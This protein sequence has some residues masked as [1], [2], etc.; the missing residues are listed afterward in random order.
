MK[1]GWLAW[2][3]MA[4]GL[5]LAASAWADPAPFDLA[6]PELRITITRHGATLP[7][8]AVP[9]LSAGD[10]LHIEALMPA[11]ETAHYVLV[12]ASL[13]DPTNPPPD[14]WFARSET[15]KRPGHGGGAIDITV[16]ADARHLVVY[17]APATI[18]DFS[19]LRDAVKGR[20]GAF[21]R[22]AQDLEQASLDR[23]RYD[24][25]LAA[26][27]KLAAQ[28]PGTL[29]KVAPVLAESLRI[30]INEE[31]L[32][33]QKELQAACLLDAKQ[34]VVLGNDDTSNINALVGV[35]TD[36][37]L[38]LSATPAG[39]MGYYSPYIS[40]IHELFGI[41]SA[42]HTAKYQYIP[43]LGVMEGER[44]RLVLNTP[45]SF[46]NP[47][48]VLMAALP[49]VKAPSPPVPQRP[50]EAAPLCYGAQAPVLSLTANPLFYATGY[51]RDLALR[52][53][54]PGAAQVDVPLSA[55]AGKGGFVAGTMAA[56]KDLTG[57][58]T[59]T[60]HGQWG[61]DSFVGP[62]VAMVV[63]GAWHWQADPAHDKS[64]LVFAGAPSACVAGVRVRA[65]HGM[66]QAEAW[67]ADGA[68]KIIVT[69]P[70]AD[71]H[72]E[73]IEVEIAGPQGVAP[74]KVAVAAPVK[75]PPP[76][77]SVVAH[78]SAPTSDEGG[79][80]IVLDSADE[81][82]ANARL[83]LTLKAA[84]DQPFADH[85]MLEITATNAS[86]SAHLSL[87]GGL[88][89]VD[90]HVLV[91]TLIPAQAL[92][93]SAY[94]SLRAR[95]VRG[96][97]PGEWMSVGKLVRLP[98]LRSLECPVDAGASCVLTGDTLYLLASVSAERSFEA[99]TSIAE[100]YPGF[101]LKIPHPGAGG[102]LFVR[103]H[104]APEVINHIGAPKAGILLPQTMPG[105]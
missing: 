77:A 88:T 31:C 101:S 46:A 70:P 99:A 55:D 52:V 84:G 47:K 80:A 21:V 104:D 12:V 49:P 5:G 63:P 15:W 42:M 8:G 28:P 33:R 13:R 76:P 7:I 16:P 102:A 2:A 39:G 56:P 69:P 1:R 38:S 64:T 60:V 11:D 29:A 4:A 59:G 78:N 95:L 25:Y 26:I 94:G 72:S 3:M 45:P 14:S 41:F 10:R 53:H 51:A 37:A 65:G 87:G 89:L 36:L 85:D 79:P 86:T 66:A 75:A 30:K 6:G 57:A 67:K 32:Q 61:F 34:S 105:R 27:R 96:G 90:S 50:A 68:D 81:I 93:S 92:G 43:A 9:Q 91:A 19:T 97:V 24:A 18:G 23:A 98:R 54:L 17:M 40:T 48:S 35:A 22:A 73:A 44:M 100:G 82:A 62:E 103:L 74:A 71:D 83:N 58:L 20:P